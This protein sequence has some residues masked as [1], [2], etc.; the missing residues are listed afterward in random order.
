MVNPWF[1]QLGATLFLSLGVP[2][3]VLAWRIGKSREAF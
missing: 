1:V 2:I 3:L